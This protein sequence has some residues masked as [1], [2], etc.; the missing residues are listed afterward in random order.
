[1]PK[2]KSKPY[3][4]TTTYYRN[5]KKNFEKENSENTKIY[6]H[7][8]RNVASTSAT[9]QIIT[10]AQDVDVHINDAHKFVYSL[11]EEFEILN[12]IPEQDEFD[13]SEDKILEDKLTLLTELRYWAISH[14]LTLAS[15]TD[16]LK[17]LRSH[18]MSE[19]PKDSRT[20]LKTP[21]VTEITEMNRGKFW[22][23]G[24]RSNLLS[25][26]SNRDILPRTIKLL[27]NIDG[28]S[29]FNSSLYQFWPISFIIEDM[30]ELQPMIAAIYYGENK[31]PLQLYFKQFVHELNEI[32]ED[33]LFIN[34]QKVTVSI[35]CFVCDTQ[36]RSYIKG[37]LL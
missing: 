29:P 16:L 3:R 6:A 1:M 21:N 13:R 35:K 37:N 20:L 14:N 7:I 23:N 17:I 31:P 27:F 4:L 34:G 33:G 24:I 2:I 26:L 8:S 18:D 25:V 15:V 9:E 12:L 28:M 22:Y 36:A 19:L 30:H 32:L 11:S 5:F 10:E